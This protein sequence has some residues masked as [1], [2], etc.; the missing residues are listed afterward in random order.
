MC[1]SDLTPTLFQLLD[2]NRD[3]R[4]GVRE[5]RTSWDRLIALEPGDADVVTKAAIQPSVSLRLT[6]GMD[7]YN[8]NQVAFDVRLQ[9]P[10]QAA[11]APQK[12]PAWFRK[13][14]RNADG[15]VSRTEYL[16]TRAE[17]DSIDADRDD[18]ISLDEAEAFDRKMRDKTLPADGKK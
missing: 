1:S 16:G 17:F 11:P 3:G 9:N 2:E 7:R 10:N 12:G 13:M 18:L 4:L 15:D 5:L 6:R 8:I 14:D